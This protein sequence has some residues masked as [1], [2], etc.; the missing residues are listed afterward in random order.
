MPQSVAGSPSVVFTIVKV[1]IETAT[2]PFTR[3]VVSFPGIYHRVMR[4]ETRKL[5]TN[6]PIMLP[7]LTW[8]QILG[9]ALP[10]RTTGVRA[11]REY[12]EK[13]QSRGETGE[14]AEAESSQ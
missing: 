7:E 13:D 12:C 1:A 11:S 5:P 4:A 6:V 10:W 3:L 8:R 2:A 14:A 9:L